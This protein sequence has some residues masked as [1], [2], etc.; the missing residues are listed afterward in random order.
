MDAQTMLDCMG[1]QMDAEKLADRSF[2]VNLKLQDGDDYLLKVHHGVLLYYKD[3]F[4]ANADLTLST[5]RMGILAIINGNLEEVNQ[6]V[7][8]EGG[9]ASLLTALCESMCAPELFFNIIEP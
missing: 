4:D 8:V 5:Q 1:I 9:D 3:T 6:L 7:P 2:T